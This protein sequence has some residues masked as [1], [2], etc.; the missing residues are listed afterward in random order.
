MPGDRPSIMRDQN[1]SGLGRDPQYGS[2]RGANHA[3]GP[4]IAEIDR[5]LPSAKAKDNSLIKI[6]VRLKTRR[7]APG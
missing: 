3:T 2:I 5:R 1:S 7:H 6:R 4:G